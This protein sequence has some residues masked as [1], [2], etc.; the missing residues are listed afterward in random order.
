M[1]VFE[2]LKEKVKSRL[3]FVIDEYPYL[4]EV[5]KSVTSIFQKGWDEYLKN[6]KIFLILYGSSVAMMEE[7]QDRFC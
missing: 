4:V 5:D 7:E 2:Y 3:I 1:E 6:T